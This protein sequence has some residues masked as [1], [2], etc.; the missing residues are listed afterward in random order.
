[1]KPKLPPE[2]EFEFVSFCKCGCGALVF[3]ATDCGNGKDR[4]LDKEIA[5][6]VRDGYEVKRVSRGEAKKLLGEREFGCSKESEQPPA[7]TQLSLL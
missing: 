1:M 6:L 2:P 5:S 3:V 4:Q 7:E